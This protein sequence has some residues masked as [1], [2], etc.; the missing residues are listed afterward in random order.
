MT[1]DYVARTMAHDDDAGVPHRD[2]PTSA[3]EQRSRLRHAMRQRSPAP[4]GSDWTPTS[5]ER[6]SKLSTS[7]LAKW[8]ADMRR[9]M[10]DD[11]L[12][13]VCNVLS[14]NPAWVRDGTP[15]MEAAAMPMSSPYAFI[16][17]RNHVPE[18]KDEPAAPSSGEGKPQGAQTSVTKSSFPAPPP[19][20]FGPAVAR[21]LN[22]PEHAFRDAQVIER[23]LATSRVL[24][25]TPADMLPGIIRRLLRAAEDIRAEGREPTAELLLSRALWSS[26]PAA[27]DELRPRH[28]AREGAHLSGGARFFWSSDDSVL[29][30]LR[31]GPLVFTVGRR[32]QR[33]DAP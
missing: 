18:I 5:L 24:D 2:S 15:P 27:G 6:A 17:P 29:R 31:V 19:D 28:P 3:R 8:F 33:G 9:E 32:G 30:V 23:V 25:A 7:T 12:A 1:L 26:P 4:D 11:T 21:A 20:V 22:I 14:L 13:K 16:M 10:R